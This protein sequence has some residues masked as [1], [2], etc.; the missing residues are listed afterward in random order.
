LK[1]LSKKIQH[2]T[3]KISVRPWS[4]QS[5][6]FVKILPRKQENFNVDVEVAEKLEILDTSLEM[7]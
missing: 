6:T 3:P 7:K 4:G 5:V 1:K 2:T